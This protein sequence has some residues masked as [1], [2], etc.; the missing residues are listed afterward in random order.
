VL[1]HIEPGHMDFDPVLTER[2]FTLLRDRGVSASFHGHAHSFRTFDREGVLY[3][4]TDA[5]DRRSYALVTISADGGVAVERVA[6]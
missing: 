1:A 5:M 2:Y 6:F 3:V 4:V